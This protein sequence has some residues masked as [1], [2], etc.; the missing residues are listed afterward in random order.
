MGR[1]AMAKKIIIKGG[2]VV[3]EAELNETAT[4][5]LIW[6][7]LPIEARA[8]LW[9][10][11]IYFAIPVKDKE[12]D[13]KE[14]VNIGDLGYWP[15]GQAFCIFFGPTPISSGGVIKP[16]SAVNIVGRV[17]GDATVFK[18]VKSREKVIINATKGTGEV[19]L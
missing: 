14:V 4:A 18:A 15:P 2:T 12:D 11:E 17:I 7:K 10:D 5:K 1:S 9:G 6:E 19:S 13:P 16:A 8:S 3:A